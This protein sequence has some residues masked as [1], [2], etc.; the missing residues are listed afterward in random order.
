MLTKKALLILMVLMIAAIALEGCATHSLPGPMATTQ[1]AETALVPTGTATTLAKVAPTNTATPV[2]TVEP[3][4]TAEFPAADYALSPGELAAK[5]IIGT[6]LE[7]TDKYQGKIPLDITVA[8]SKTIETQFGP[9]KCVPNQKMAELDKTRSAEER[10]Q[11]T[12]LLGYYMG[13]VRDKG[14]TENNYSFDQYLASLAAGRDMSFQVYGKKLD[15]TMG[16]FMAKPGVFQLVVIAPPA[17]L[18]GDDIVTSKPF[19]W[20]GY[21]SQQLPGGGLRFVAEM[22]G[23]YT[24][25]EFCIELSMNYNVGFG[26]MGNII[27]DM[28][29]HHSSYGLPVD[30]FPKT[31]ARLNGTSADPEVWTK[32]GISAWIFIKP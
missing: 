28:D 2:P 14:L 5:G 11:E 15:G 24:N 18:Y 19:L 22:H 17:A 13:Y 27:S 3:T 7:I 26:V 29:G 20:N 1:P 16:T 23:P 31:I 12:A 10:A 32:Y 25:D 30:K 4:P 8:L 9:M 6:G 21:T